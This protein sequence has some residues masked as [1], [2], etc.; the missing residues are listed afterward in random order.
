MRYMFASLLVLVLSTAADAAICMGG[1]GSDGG[2]PCGCGWYGPSGFSPEYWAANCYPPCY[3]PFYYP[4]YNPFCGARVRS[5]SYGE[6]YISDP[7]PK[8]K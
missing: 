1:A 8:K 5:N 3:A 7:L 4:I 2:G 6:R